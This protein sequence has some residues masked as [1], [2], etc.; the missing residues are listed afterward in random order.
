MNY[1]NLAEELEFAGQVGGALS[2]EVRIKLELVLRKM[3][4]T[5]QFDSLGFWGRING[6]SRDYF[7]VLGLR[8][9]GFREN[10]QKTFLWAYE[11]FNF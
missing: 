6:V 5:E 8:F 2:P 4:Q 10:P 3:Q 9:Q 11:D 7:I 1:E